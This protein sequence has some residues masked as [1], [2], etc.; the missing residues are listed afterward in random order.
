LRLSAVAGSVDRGDEIADHFHS[1]REI[2][3][4][5]A[6]RRFDRTHF[7]LG[8]LEQLRACHHF[9]DVGSLDGNDC[10]LEKWIDLAQLLDRADHEAFAY[11]PV[12]VAVG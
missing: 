6:L 11:G 5:D 8:R 1:I 7:A 9:I 10:R 3:H 2:E 4:N 12:V